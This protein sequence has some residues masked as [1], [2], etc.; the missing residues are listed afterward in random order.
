MGIGAIP[1]NWKF[2]G[3]PTS[4][5][6]FAALQEATEAAREGDGEQP[7]PGQELQATPVWVWVA[8]AVAVGGVAALGFNLGWFGKR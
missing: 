8:G 5:E 6:K 7:P 4:R 1:K 2:L 3:T